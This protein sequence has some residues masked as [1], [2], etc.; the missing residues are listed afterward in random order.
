[1]KK[2]I[3]LKIV[4]LALTLSAISCEK[5]EWNEIEYLLCLS[6]GKS[7]L[8]EDSHLATLPPVI[9]SYLEAT[10][11]VGTYYANSIKFT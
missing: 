7:Y 9:Q 8:I 10:G 2:L 5:S 3:K 11:V 6:E 4:A 1:M